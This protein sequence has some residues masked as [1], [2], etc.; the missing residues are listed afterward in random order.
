MCKRVEILILIFLAVHVAA[1]QNHGTDQLKFDK[2]A[3]SNGLSDN[4]VRAIHKDHKGYLWVGTWN[5]LNRYNGKQFKVYKNAFGD[6]T[7]L[8]TNKVNCI[9]ERTN[10]E[11]WI[12]CV[13][14]YVSIYN[15]DLDRFKWLI[16]PPDSK[17]RT[18]INAT[19]VFEKSP[20]E[21]FI[22]TKGNGLDIYN[23]AKKEFKRYLANENDPFS[24]SSNF[25]ND[26]VSDKEGQIWIA[27]D[28]G[29]NLYKDDT[30]IPLKIGT[31]NQEI[32]KI[33]CLYKDYRNRLWIGTNQGVY[34]FNLDNNS[35]LNQKRLETK[36]V[37]FLKN[38]L[39]RTIHGNSK[40]IIY[41]GGEE[42]FYVYDLEL[43]EQI[44]YLPG[45]SLTSIGSESIYDILTDD[46]EILWLGTYNSGLNYYSPLAHPYE[47]IRVNN[48]GLNSQHISEIF[49]ASN[50]KVWITTDGG[51]VNVMDKKTFN[52]AYFTHKKND[53]TSISS[54][55]TICITEDN[56]HKIW[57]GTYD[58]GLNRYDPK[59]QTFD[60]FLVNPDNPFSIAENH[61]RDLVFDNNNELWILF[62]KNLQKYDRKNNRFI[63]VL[64]EYDIPYNYQF[65]TMKIDSKNNIW[66]GGYLGIVH[67]DRST[68]KK[69]VFYHNINGPV[70]ENFNVLC[71]Y[72]DTKGRMWVGLDEGGMKCFYNDSFDFKQYTVKE[73][74]P[75]NSISNIF[76]DDLNNIW[77][78]SYLGLSKIANGMLLPQTIDS[79]S[80]N[81]ESNK[82]GYDY[83]NKCIHKNKEGVVY[84]GGNFGF[85]ILNPNT[86]KENPYKPN[87]VFTQLRLF[88]QKVSPFQKDSPLSKVISETKTLTLTPEQKVFTIEFV[89]L[90][91]IL[92]SKNQYAYRL[93]GFDEP[94]TW[95]YIGTK[96][97]ITYTN[98]NP[99]KYTL[100]VIASNN[101]GIWNRKGT[102][103]KIVIL[104]PFWKTWWFRLIVL[105]AITAIILLWIYIRTHNLNQKKRE[106]E[107]LVNKRTSKINQQNKM[108]EMQTEDLTRINQELKSKQLEIVEQKNNIENMAAQLQ[109]ATTNKLR[110][111]TNI[112]HEFKTPLTLIL[113][114]LE[115]LLAKENDSA[116]KDY[117]SIINRNAK[118]LFNLINQ[119]IDLRRID[120]SKLHLQLSKNDIVEHCENIV[121]L[122]S[123]LSKE[124][125]IELTFKPEVK[126][127][128]HW[129]DADKLEKILYNLISNAFKFTASKGKIQL[130]IRQS[131]RRE[132]IDETHTGFVEISLSDTGKGIESERIDK[133]F[134]R[135]YHIESPKTTK[136][137]G[138]GIGLSYVKE[139]VEIHKGKIEVKSSVGKGTTFT[140]LLPDSKDVFGADDFL[141]K[142]SR[143]NFS[144]SKNALNVEFNVSAEKDTE[145]VKKQ[146]KELILIVDDNKD[147]RD[148]LCNELKKQYQIIRAENGESA[149][150]KTRKYLPDLVICDVMMPIMNGLE[151]AQKIKTEM[152]TSHIPVILLTA[153]TEEQHKIK[154]FEQGADDYIT[155]PFHIDTLKARI[156]N[157]IT[158]R[159]QLRESFGA[160]AD[161]N[162]VSD[163]LS[164]QSMDRKFLEKAIKVIEKNFA[165]PEFDNKMF[166]A[167]MFMGKSQL[168]AKL[169]ALT[170]QTAHEFIKTVRLK[171]ASELLKT[172]DYNISEI[173]YLT[174]FN[175]PV[176]FSKCFK[177]SF[178]ISPSEHQDKTDKKKQW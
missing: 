40:G 102:S 152:L 69:R 37:D 14:G 148:F 44:K 112:S 85:N 83:T 134:D 30:F 170:N 138:T 114:P 159:K 19:V 95:N 107:I 108:L 118:R 86:I 117:L 29:L 61:V 16:P 74:L 72:E 166:A 111:F 94:E 121:S 23:P 153:K 25:V 81:A 154:G 110:F 53:P 167:E 12:G 96:N 141:E 5:G 115:Q 126:K 31:Q 4:W 62:A 136:Y 155:K 49:E 120:Q 57:V 26:I 34:V 38:K 9:C 71:L 58:N 144:Y 106:L 51:G 82:T 123:N 59:K 27:T 8:R 146:D 15:R 145:I 143:T 130:V 93:D 87:I 35:I 76:Q 65:H 99:G 56:E 131:D 129:F 178:G 119:L 79:K 20:T 75:H 39:V 77:I 90:N 100:R 147:L 54:D 168:Y 165:N 78:S 101:D 22:G 68:K 60:R 73:G 92:P 70:H 33:F 63:H 113:G 116:K 84:I 128:M 97:E 28:N 125:D 42:G 52:F 6:S 127:T 151:Y 45:N 157:L 98:L 162:L 105:F 91:Y 89:A 137:E 32:K 132:R 55:K 88:N 124:S 11:L 24:I 18:N 103:L 150:N 177:D 156:K 41:L 173:A 10:G 135:F 122:F 161:Q 109:E 17:G 64:N 133:L 48:S 171:K 158:S 174:G 36:S 13:G 175:S 142:A 140:I 47:K 172:T 7:S 160:S 139:L 176:Y 46:T 80:Y 66:L 3:V 163:K 149:I 2:L 50:G 164:Y 1:A 67:I 104:P 169:K 21:I 43:N